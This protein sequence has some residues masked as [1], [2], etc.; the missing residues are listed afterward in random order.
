MAQAAELRPVTFAVADTAGIRGHIREQG[1]VRLDPLPARAVSS[2]TPTPRSPRRR[3][4]AVVRD[5]ATP[6][7]LEEAR[8]LLWRHLGETHGW[9]PDE[10]KSWTDAAYEAPA[11]ARG[12]GGGHGLGGNPRS[13]LLGSTVHS[14]CFWYCRTLPGVLTAFAAA[15][16]CPLCAFCEAE[17][18]EEAKRAAAAAQTARTTS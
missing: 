2:R 18:R 16:K 7:E 12:E 17:K 3:W 14:D 9:R 1:Y 10:P 11:A 6:S 5:A 8:A 15:C 13:G 4:Q